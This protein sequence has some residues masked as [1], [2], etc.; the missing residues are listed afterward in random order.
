MHLRHMQAL[1]APLLVPSVNSRG[2]P[3]KH[4]SPLFAEEEIGRE[5]ADFLIQPVNQLPRNQRVL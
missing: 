3:R 1:C 4:E 2:A 5:I